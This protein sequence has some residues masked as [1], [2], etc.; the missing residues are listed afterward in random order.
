MNERE[1][2]HFASIKFVRSV[3]SPVRRDQQAC[4]ACPSYEATCINAMATENRAKRFSKARKTVFLS[5]LFVCSIL[6]L[7]SAWKKTNEPTNGF[8]STKSALQLRLRLR[9]GYTA[10]GYGNGHGRRA[11][12]F[13]PKFSK[14][15]WC[16]C[17]SVVQEVARPGGQEGENFRGRVI[18]LYLLAARG[19]RSRDILRRR[20]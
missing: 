3:V 11:F 2:S 12:N 9:L 13:V 10:M 6:Y 4:R 8:R 7:R 18:N 20:L 17:R 14:V 1:G 16:G 19:K 15:V 5:P